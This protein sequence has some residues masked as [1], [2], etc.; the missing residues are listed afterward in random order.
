MTDLEKARALL[1]Q[2]GATCVLCRGDTT[3]SDT[4]RGIRPLLELLD[5]GKDFSD[6]AAA[7][8]VVGKAAAHIYC[9][10]GIRQLYAGTVSQPALDLLTE[11]GVDICW[12]NPVPAIQNRTQTGLCP[13]E[14]AVWNISGHAEAVQALRTTLAELSNGHTI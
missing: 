2:T 3:I 9:L 5:S 12:E 1:R 14:S 13:M 10:L 7:D 6:Y 4:R 11:N 8:K